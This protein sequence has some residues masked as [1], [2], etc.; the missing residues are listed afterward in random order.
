[1]SPKAS[2]GRKILYVTSEVTPFAKT[3]GLADVSAALPLSLHRRGHDV[4][5]FVPLYSAVDVEAYD[6]DPVDGLTD[7]SFNLG[8]RTCTFSVFRSLLPGSDLGIHFIHCPEFYDR[9]SLYTNDPDEHLRFILLTRGALEA[10]QRM[11]WSP[12]IAHA[13]DWQAGLLP[14][15]LKTL[16]QW[17]RLFQA[18]KSVLTIHNIGYQGIFKSDI[19]ADTGLQPASH[20]LDQAELKAGRIGFLRTGLEHADWLTTVSPTYAKEILSE[21]FG[22]G[23]APILKRRED[24]LRGILNGIDTDIWNPREDPN[25]THRYSAKSLWRKEKNKESLLTELGLPYEKRVPVIGMISRLAGQKGF[26]LLEEPLPEILKQRDIRLVVLGDGENRFES[27]FEQLESDFPDK[28]RFWRGYNPEL[29]HRIEAGS[30]LFLMPS[31][32]E[33]CGLNQ[34]YS[35]VYG[36]VPIVHRTGGLADTVQLW[37]PADETGNGIVFDHPTP[38]GVRWAINSALDLFADPKAWKKLV[39]NG[40]DEDFSWT[41]RVEEYEALYARALTPEEAEANEEAKV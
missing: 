28:V 13:H 15:Y 29:A 14:L 31:Y 9:P 34:M 40:M 33:P 24:R 16:Y 18:T 10:C 23:M 8:N 12:E 20:Y 38:D 6:F 1:M 11:Q 32:Y 21:R 39:L 35:M 30:D 25:L 37:D 41:A 27:F 3:G 22:M 19:L 7:V 2:S 26:D 17:D 5:V 4:R 36:T